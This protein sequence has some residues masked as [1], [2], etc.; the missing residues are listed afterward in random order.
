MPTARRVQEDSCSMGWVQVGEE[1][2]IDAEDV[3][4]VRTLKTL[5][6][7]SREALEEHRVD[8][9]PYRSWCDECV[10]GAGREDGHSKV[11]SHSIP[12]L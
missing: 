8:H 1:I 6:L 4:P 11:E 7:P 5:E 3:Q 12:L 2:S 9:S 10:E